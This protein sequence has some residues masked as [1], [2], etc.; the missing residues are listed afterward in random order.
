MICLQVHCFFLIEPAVVSIELFSS[1]IVIFSFGVFIVPIPL[2]NFS[3][4]SYVI[5]LILFSCL[6]FIVDL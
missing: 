1:I 2:L 4:C 6:C 3:V 5:F